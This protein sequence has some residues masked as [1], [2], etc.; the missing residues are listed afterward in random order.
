[1]P[2]PPTELETLCKAFKIRRHPDT[3]FTAIGPLGLFSLKMEAQ[4]A[5][6]VQVTT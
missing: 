3:L 2:K 1:M 5:G 6:L 4:R